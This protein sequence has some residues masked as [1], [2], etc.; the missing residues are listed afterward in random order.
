MSTT[1]DQKDKISR[2]NWFVNKALTALQSDDK[3]SGSDNVKDRQTKK[4]N[5][6]SKN[7]RSLKDDD[8][9]D[10]GWSGFQY[11]TREE[12]VLKQQVKY[13]HLKDEIILDTGSTLPATFMNPKL[14]TEIKETKILLI[15]NMNVGAKKITKQANVI[16]YGK[17]W[18][19][20]DQM[21]NIFGFTGTVDQYRVKYDS[22]VEDAFTVYTEN[23]L[24]KFKRNND[25]LYTYKPKE[26]YLREVKET[27]KKTGV[28]NIVTTLKEN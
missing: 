21:A 10:S 17:A 6:S 18:F 22:M 19:D 15:M 11:F 16:G 5:K 26:Q 14:V 13:L 23:G 4:T 9:E 25:G 1:C 28:V 7:S 3:K 24:I 12:T 8:E 20:E 27:K 2:E